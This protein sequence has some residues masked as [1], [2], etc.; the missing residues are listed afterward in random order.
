MLTL[1]IDYEVLP[2]RLVTIQLP[3][4]VRPGRHELVIVLEKNNADES[5]T[6]TNGKMLME[7]AGSVTAFDQVDGVDYQKRVRAEWN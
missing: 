4:T 6:D 1:N 3:K 2:N 7:F 5:V